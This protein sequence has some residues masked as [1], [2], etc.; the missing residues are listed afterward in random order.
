MHEYNA[1]EK[2]IVSGWF[3]KGND[4]VVII[5]IKKVVSIFPQTG[6]VI[7]TI[8]DIPIRVINNKLRAPAPSANAGEIHRAVIQMNN[9]ILETETGMLLIFM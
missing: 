6:Y 4:I 3:N 1:V 2:R 7:K 9:K 5:S 8:G